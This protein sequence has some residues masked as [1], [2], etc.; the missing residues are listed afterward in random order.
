MRIAVVQQSAHGR[1]VDRNIALTRHWVAHAADAGADI[2]VFPGTWNIGHQ[3]PTAAELESAEARQTL[4]QAQRRY[5]AA[6]EEAAWKSG[7]AVVATY[8]DVDDGETP[9]TAHNTAHNAAALIDP[10]GDTV[11]TYREVGPA[12]FTGE[13]APGRDVATADL[14]LADG[15]QVRVGL[16][17][18]HDRDFPDAALSL[19]H[20]GAELVLIPNAGPLCVNRLWQVRTRGFENRYAVALAN[21]PEP[22]Y[23]GRS[24]VCDGI[25]F[26]DGGNPRDH[27]VLLA[28]ETAG[29]HIVSLSLDALRH[30]RDTRPWGLPDDVTAPLPSTPQPG[31]APQTDHPANGLSA[32]WGRYHT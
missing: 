32:P 24:L 21:Y 1:D 19:A 29:T 4:L 14:D 28:D 15:D 3:L 13:G 23:S 30:Y 7:V 25:A 12:R 27:T 18:C 8:L 31:A 26:D 5:L 17:I 16:L 6:A 11:L 2:A 10:S 22:P 9:N 20:Q